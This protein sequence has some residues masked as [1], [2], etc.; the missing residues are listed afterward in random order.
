[1]EIIR[2]L[3]PLSV[4]V[5]FA[6][7]RRQPPWQQLDEVVVLDQQAAARAQH[8]MR[9]AQHI[10]VRVVVE[11]PK[12]REPAHHGHDALRCWEAH[13]PLFRQRDRD[14]MRFAFDLWSH[15]DVT[16]RADAILPRLQ[17]GTMPCD[18]AWPP[19]RTAVF[20]RWVT[21]GTPT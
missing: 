20:Q 16:T 1:M 9:L 17:A 18:G 3:C 11:I 6:D 10:A 15:E 2:R 12:R 7:D 14:S 13:K 5:A 21:A 19:E 4:A 8:S